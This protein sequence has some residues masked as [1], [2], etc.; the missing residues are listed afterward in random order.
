MLEQRLG[1]ALCDTAVLL[2]SN[3]HRVEDTTAVIHGEVVDEACVTGLFVDLDDGDVRAERVGGVALGEIEFVGELVALL[4]RLGRELNPRD[5]LGGHA[6]DLEATVTLHDVSLRGL[7]QTG[8]NLLALLQHVLAGDEHCRP[9][10]LQRTRTHRA[11]TARHEVR[12]G[13]HVADLVHRNAEL[14]GDDHRER[15]VVRLAVA[16]RTDHHRCATVVIDGDLAVLGEQT[17]R[18]GDL[19]V[20]RNA[21][22][23]DLDGTA[24]DA[25]L[26]LGAQTL[27]V[28]ELQR[29]VEGLLVVTRV[30]VG[31]GDG[32]VRELRGLNEVLAA[33][34]GGIDTRHVCCDVQNALEHL[35][36]LGATGAAIR[37]GWGGVGDHRLGIE[38]DLRDVVHTLA[39]HLGEHRE[40]GA[41]HR[42]GA[43]VGD[44]AC[45]QTDD[46]AVLLDTHLDV[47]DVATTVAHRQH[48][49]GAAL[50]PLHRALEQQSGLGADFVLDVV[51][52][53]RAEPA[54]DPRSD[55]PDLLGIHADSG[56]QCWLDGMSGL[57]GDDELQAIALGDGDARVGLHRH[58]GK[59][60][61]EDAGL[62]HDIRTLEGV[63]VRTESGGECDVA[64]EFLEQQDATGE[65]LLEINHSGHDVVVHDD[66]LGG[67]LTLVQVGGDD[68]C[69]NVAD[70]ADLAAGE[71]RAHVLRGASKSD[72]VRQIEIVGG[73]DRQ[74]ARH[75]LGAR[76]VN[77]DD[78]TMSDRRTDE[79]DVR[80]VR[81]LHVVGVLVRTPE[82]AWIL[83]PKDR[84]AENG[85]GAG[86]SHGDTFL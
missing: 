86:L 47:H 75:V 22:T 66:L 19:D 41:D 67:V 15:R 52:G 33:D 4:L 29:G 11:R 78:A 80:H 64:A 28:R 73:V 34:L 58:A 42:V 63:G 2:A 5:D 21:D 59:A 10:S 44:A 32:G 46:R 79:H 48:V 13:L 31:T 57:G 45:V 68:R 39:E 18:G 65:R 62:G 38:V 12:V 51:G 54:T 37:H 56:S 61:A 6:G 24:R 1:D 82:Q 77:A 83:L 55:N 71:R 3:K 30:V 72:V 49:L 20:R 14:V 35:R 23:E 74:H 84:V 16:R 40:H 9:S 76:D 7:E 43:A 81:E 69:N 27:V 8:S 70:E 36:G 17:E 60:L 50:G 85:A 25:T 53:L 26:L